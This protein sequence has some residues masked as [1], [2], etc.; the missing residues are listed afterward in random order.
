VE[1]L[2]GVE[3]CVYLAGQLMDLRPHLAAALQDGGGDNLVV[4][5]PDITELVAELRAPA[6]FGAVNK[7]LQLDQALSLMA[8]VR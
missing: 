4:V 8:K 2:V 7:M 3:S 5:V 1:R 6:F